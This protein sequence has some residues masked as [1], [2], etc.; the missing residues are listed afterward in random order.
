[1]KNLLLDWMMA[2]SRCRHVDFVI[3]REEGMLKL[4]RSLKPGRL[5]VFLPDEDLGSEHA[6][7]APFFGK[8]KAT[9][10]TPERIAKL[11]KASCFPCYTYY[12]EKTSQYCV[13]L[14]KRLSPFPATDSQKSA[15]VLNK[16]IENLIQIEPDQYMWLLKLYKTRRQG[17]ASI[18]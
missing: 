1:V 15:E 2:K 18:Y 8:D 4:V 5:L 3:S 6:N 12:D 13:R 7:F 9:L 14:G 16:S 11:K 17:R 10:N